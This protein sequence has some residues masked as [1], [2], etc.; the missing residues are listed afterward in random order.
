MKKS[1][2]FLFVI[3]LITTFAVKAQKSS[4]SETYGHTLNLGLGIGGYSG[5]SGYVG[6][7]L[8]VIHV[9]YEFEVIKN[10][11][12]APFADFFSYSNSYFYGNNNYYY[13][14]TVIPIGAKG[15]YYF[16]QLLNANSKWD[17]YLAGSLGYAIVFSR[18]DTGYTGD[19]NYFR[20]ASPLFL[21]IHIGSEYH[22]N[23]RLGISL[24]ISGD[25]PTV[26]LA[27]H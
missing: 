17:F 6:R 25:G 2:I 18:W 9:D 7:S 12:I 14:E 27:L 24:D 16:D 8:P 10:F 20:Q 22:I 4:Y 19:K 5:Y 23:K 1:I 3:M 21:N 11:T 15:T 26:C 13:R